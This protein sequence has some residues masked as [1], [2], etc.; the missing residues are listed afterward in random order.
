MDIRASKVL[1]GTVEE[2]VDF[3]WVARKGICENIKQQL[4]EFSKKEHL[5][6]MKLLFLQSDQHW[7]D[8]KIDY[9]LST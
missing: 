3:E 8:S 7:K 2:P 4:A 9:I 1:I 6:A 5:R